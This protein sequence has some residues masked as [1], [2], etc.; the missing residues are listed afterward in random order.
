VTDPVAQATYGARGLSVGTILTT[1]TDALDL[2]AWLLASHVPS[3]AWAGSGMEWDL[4]S[5]ERN[6]ATAQ[7]LVR[8]LLDSSTRP[9][10]PI[11]LTNLPEWT[12]TAAAAGMFVEGGTYRYRDGAWTLAL[13]TA[14]A[15]GVGQTMTFAQTNRTVRYVDVDPAVSYLEMN[16]VGP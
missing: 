4:A 11:V 6:D 7:A 16:G 14:S 1:Q 12:P 9:G 10:L 5:A 2:A 3:D 13:D 8:N 15:V